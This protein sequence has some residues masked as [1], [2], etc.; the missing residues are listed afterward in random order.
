MGEYF[1]TV[2]KPRLMK[3]AFSAN[4]KDGIPQDRDG[5]SHIIKYHVLESYEDALN[6]LRIAEP[7][8]AMREL[9][10][11]TFDDY[12]LHYMLDHETKGS[13]SLLAQD[14]FEK[15]FAYK[16]Q[17]QRGHATPEPTVVDLE[18]TFNYLIGLR[19]RQRC[20]HE[21]QGRRYVVVR[22]TVETETGIEKVIVLWRDTE[23]LDHDAE[24][25]WAAETVLTEP[26]DRVYVNGASYIRGAEPLEIAFRTRMDVGARA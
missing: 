10:Y 23:G 9:L 26:V 5:Q 18:E 17:I 24:A 22:G 12:Q 14:A 8:G 21:H 2:L 7:E 1:D 20:I 19:V 11:G 16:L 15:P 4:W 3:V 6:N 13:R 25:I